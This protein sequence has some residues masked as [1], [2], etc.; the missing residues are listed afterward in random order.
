MCDSSGHNVQEVG[1]DEGG[2]GSLPA[3]VTGRRPR[4]SN[5]DSSTVVR[6]CVPDLISGACS[7]LSVDAPLP[8][9]V[10]PL[11]SKSTS[12][13]HLEIRSLQGRRLTAVSL[14]RILPPFNH[15]LSS[16]RFTLP[17]TFCLALAAP[18]GQPRH[19][20]IRMPAWTLNGGRRTGSQRFVS[21]SRVWPTGTLGEARARAS[22]ATSPTRSF[23]T[24]F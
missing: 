21:S 16:L 19:D 20:D 3:A 8:S 12:C 18:F 4:T 17:S 14:C 23:E 1:P 11:P 22:Y 7:Y 2:Q 24:S 9:W 13:P 6:P 5:L 10:P 15:P